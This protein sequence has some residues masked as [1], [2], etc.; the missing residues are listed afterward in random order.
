MMRSVVWVGFVLGGILCLSSSLHAQNRSRIL[1]NTE[2]RLTAEMDRNVQQALEEAGDLLLEKEFGPAVL[3]LQS[4]LDHP[5]DYFVEKD[6]QS[7]E[8]LTSKGVALKVLADL[9]AEGRAAYELQ[10]GTD[11]RAELADAIAAEDY[12]R[13]SE[14]VSRYQ[15]TAAG[16]QGMQLLAARALDRNHPMQ[17]ALI[18]EAMRE[19]PNS[20]GEFR[21]PLLLQ[22]ALA[23]HLADQPERARTA[24][25]GLDKLKQAGPWQVAGRAVTPFPSLGEAPAWLQTQFG[26][27][28]PQPPAVVDRW[29]LPRGGLT[30]NESAAA[31]CPV[32]G[33]AWKIS[34]RQHLRLHMNDEINQQRIKGFDQMMVQTEQM[35][36]EGNRLTQPAAI[37]IVVGD[38]VVYRTINDLTAVSLKTGD[39]L[40]RSAKTDGMLTW[41]FQSPLAASDAIPPSSPLTFR[42]YLQFKMFRDQISGSLSSDGDRVYAVEESESQFSSL[43]PRS[44]LPFGA[45]M[46][47]DP[48]NKLSA[49][50]VAGGR[51]LWEVGGQNGTPPAELS[52]MYFVG[53]PVPCDGRLYCLAESKNEL[54]LLCLIPESNTARLEWYQTLVAT[55]R[56]PFGATFRFAGLIPATAEGLMV[57]PTANGAIVAYDIVRRQLR[58]GYSYDSKSRR[59]FQDNFENPVM[60]ERVGGDDEESR[61]LDSGPVITRGR[62]LVTPRDSHEIH[63]INLVDGSLN[64]KRSQAQGLYLACVNE[65]QVVVVG[66]NQIA[67]YSLADG[68]EEWT[69]PME[70]PEPSGRGVR[71]GKQY[72]LP[73]STGDIATLDLTTGR[74]LGRSKLPQAGVPG[75]LAV[76]DGALV[77]VGTHDVIGFRSLGEV[78]DQVA[79]QLAKNP[80]D[81]EALALRGELKLHRGQELEAIEDLRKSLRQ[82]P[83]PAVK[84]VLAETMLNRLRNDPKSILAAATE[85]EALTEDPLQ[86]VEFLR[87]YANSLKESGDRVGAI[88]EYFRLALTTTI[89]DMMIS[90]GTGHFVSLEQSVRAELFAIYDA[91]TASERTE[92]ERVFSRE[93]E[94]AAK[95]PD[96]N[97][98]IPHLIKLTSGHPAAD[99]LLLK[100]AE[101][102]GA[103]AD[104]FAR[105]Q[106]LERITSSANLS[107]A[108]SA[109]ASLAALYIAANAPEE[110]RPWIAELGDRFAT[111]VC[112]DGKTG[113]QLSDEWST[114]RSLGQDDS[115]FQWPQ[116]AIEVVRTDQSITQPAFPV[117]VVTHVG[118]FYK[119]WSF[120]VDAL[121][122]TLTARDPHLNVVWRVPLINSANDLRDQPCQLHIRGRRLALASGTWLGVMEAVTTQI[123][124]EIIFEQSLR[125][126][127][128]VAPRLSTTP[129]ERRL[130]PNGRLIQLKS[131][132]RSTA[133]YLVGLTDDAVVYQLDNRLYAADPESGKLLWSRVGPAFAKVDATVDS[134]LM[135]ATAGNG[136]LLLRMRDG[137]IEQQHK[138]NPNDVPLWFRG[139]RRLTQR[140]QVPDQRVFEMHDFDGDRVVWQSQHPVGSKACLIQ[141]EELAILEPTSKLTI[142][143]LATGE[144]QLET[145]LPLKRPL[146]GMLVLSVQSTPD[147]YI[148]V[149]GVSIRKTELRRIE[150]INFGM[151]PEFG[152]P[153]ELGTPSNSAFSLDGMVFYIDRKS[154][155]VKWSVPVN[156]LAYDAN[157]PA[158]LPVL[159]LAAWNIHFDPNT[160]FPLDPKLSTLILDKRTGDV[161]YKSQELATPVGRGLQFIPSH[162]TKK[163]LI[164]FYSFQ[165]ELKFPKPK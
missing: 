91:A 25:E 42:G 45:Q 31:S 135:L 34:S 54:R 120:E 69:Q 55:E 129:N 160:G 146:R 1:F 67:A 125:P 2:S 108:G 140:N 84:R 153:R 122:T 102:P 86:R 165:L 149:A 41:L 14:L 15:L 109:A 22:T 72:L 39:L 92:M 65:D 159:V 113:R 26:P 35:M 142:L 95:S 56:A 66:R 130:L 7:G 6:F 20:Q 61:W 96:R 44:R 127:S 57:C 12:V 49:Y 101:A 107:V 18:Y 163:L 27:T 145:E 93:F 158:S 136:A 150:P 139:T 19:H 47:M 90:A 50:D 118:S 161:V 99:A 11:A 76:G 110:A 77:S 80:D 62:V 106:L 58:W 48:V 123:A 63:C 156:E 114:Q 3:R 157:Q 133:G 103:I 40:W 82:R 73:L 141:D 144:K 98:R 29:E 81:A 5:E 16:F 88:T 124:P 155:E 126:N 151:P 10:V 131:D 51:L 111:I 38:V 75:N 13:V 116:G 154:G 121:I 104:E 119:G 89:P 85:L 138:G 46:I 43:L 59:N 97:D 79:E 134:K 8:Q 24:L 70:I 147:H 143:K 17:A 148:V 112:S 60:R 83:D 87:L 78:E 37:P 68:S 115:R 52:G 4:V 117:E 23:W 32:G 137:A 94:T 36:R 28:A 9:P 100:L 162:E 21:I 164:D 105:L 30:G 152:L 128:F 71:V 53:P 132:G 33:G 74:I 64:W